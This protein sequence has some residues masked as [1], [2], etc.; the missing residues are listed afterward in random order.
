MKTIWKGNRGLIMNHNTL[1]WY[2]SNLEFPQ[3][4]TLVYFCGKSSTSE[5]EKQLHKSDCGEEELLTLNKL[6]LHTVSLKH[7]MKNSMQAL[8]TDWEFKK[9]TSIQ[10]VKR[11]DLFLLL[12][13]VGLCWKIQI[14]NIIATSSLKI[15]CT[16]NKYDQLFCC[17]VVSIELNIL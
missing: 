3:C 10:R 9:R 2:S 14:W 4:S 8:E 15:I 6:H 7:P 13:M 17:F 5:I 11:E 12:Y 1:F 16:F